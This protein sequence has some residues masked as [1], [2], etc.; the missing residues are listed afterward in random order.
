MFT[1]ST[2][3][4]YEQKNLRRDIGKLGKRAGLGS[5]VTP[6]SLRHSACTILSTEGVAIE[7]VADV[8]GHVDTRMVMKHYRHQVAPSVTAAVSM[9]SKRLRPTGSQ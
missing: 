6:Y 7:L 3:T 9:S 5:N 4:P 2:G 8:L 1:T